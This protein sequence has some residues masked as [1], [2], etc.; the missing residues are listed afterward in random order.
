VGGW[1]V[2]DKRRGEQTDRGNQ[3]GYPER[4]VHDVSS[5]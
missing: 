1:R 3:T 4:A 5:F 2:D